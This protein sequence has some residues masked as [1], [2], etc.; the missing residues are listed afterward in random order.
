[1][2]KFR[3]YDDALPNIIVGLISEA[4]GRIRHADLIKM[5]SQTTINTMHEAGIIRKEGDYFVLVPEGMPRQVRFTM[6]EARLIKSLFDLGETEYTF[7]EAIEHYGYST[8]SDTFIYRL[9]IKG[10][11][12]R[13]ERRTM[14]VNKDIA[15]LVIR[16]IDPTGITV[17]ETTIPSPFQRISNSKKKQLPLI[18]QEA[19]DELKSVERP[20]V[21]PEAQIAKQETPTALGRNSVTVSRLCMYLLEGDCE[22]LGL[23]IEELLDR[24]VLRCFSLMPSDDKL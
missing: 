21:H 3:K 11:I 19:Q 5:I 9:A 8:R 18:K 24:I 15:E 6:R 13:T 4:G 22:R 17:I 12:Y 7:E 20:K 16:N 14:L 2:R 23:T 1:M 10:A